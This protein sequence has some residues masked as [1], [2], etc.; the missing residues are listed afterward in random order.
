[1]K[2]TKQTKIKN[3]TA[4]CIKKEDFEILIKIKNFKVDI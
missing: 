1:M 2:K 3:F 4:K